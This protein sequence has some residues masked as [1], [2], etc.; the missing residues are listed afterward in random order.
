M[1]Q[2][3]IHYFNPVLA[4]WFLGASVSLTSPNLSPA[5]LAKQL[6]EVNIRVI[7]CNDYSIQSVLE[8]VEIFQKSSTQD[9]DVG[10]FSKSFL[11][12]I[13]YKLIFT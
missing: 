4:S 8:G 6:S 13:K 9:S 7:F 11:L 1:V 3:N 5:N 10:S 12:L 2:N